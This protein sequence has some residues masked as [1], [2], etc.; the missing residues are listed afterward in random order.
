MSYREKRSSSWSHWD[1]L[2][3][4][5]FSITVSLSYLKSLSQLDC[6]LIEGRDLDVYVCVCIFISPASN[7]VSSNWELLTCLHE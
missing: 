7:D 4:S 6:E 2:F 3:I 5:L 1:S